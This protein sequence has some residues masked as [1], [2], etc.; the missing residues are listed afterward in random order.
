MSLRRRILLAFIATL[1][2]AAFATSIWIR[3]EARDSYALVIEEMMVD[4]ANLLAIQLE[5]EF[6]QGRPGSLEIARVFETFKKRALNAQILRIKKVDPALDIY[7][8]DS[9]GR[10][11]YSSRD[12]TEIGQDYSQ[13]RDIALTLRGEY[14]ARATRIDQADKLTS[15]YYIGAPIRVGQE[16]VGVV[17][18]IKK[19]SSITAFLDLFLEKMVIGV[20]VVIGLV[21][22]FGS[23]L[24]VWI[25]RP[26]EK[27]R[28]YALE[29]AS[30]NKVPLPNL[31]HRELRDL[32]DAFEQMRISLEGRKTIERFIQ[33]LTHELKSPLAAI[34]GSS[35]LALEPMADA[36]RTRFLNNVLDEAARAELVLEQMMRIAALES[37][38][39][40]TQTKS[41][42]LAQLVGDAETAL[43]GI[44]E[45]SQV[46]F[47]NQWDQQEPNFV[48][49]ADPFLLTQAIRNLLQNAVEFSEAGSE[50]KVSLVRGDTKIR[51]IVEDSGSG[52]P[53]FAKERMFEKFV[54]LERPRTGKKGTGLGLSF[55]REVIHLH[56]G[57]IEVTSP[58]PSGNRGTRIE[59]TL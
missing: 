11:L 30:G 5:T 59:I 47:I 12:A 14:G 56:R 8:T 39:K 45:K 16:I 4:V 2:T 57:T 35:E 34:R 37:Q 54:S 6:A 32:A 33:S 43:L 48:V 58:L 25:T 29:I 51:L 1:F 50:V 26:I 15:V 31:P 36:Q 21:I 53:E 3:N 22:F 23:L 44:A 40:L 20:L 38:T 10:V 24:F 18:A 49:E 41:S 42:N 17:T 13:W 9:T 28:G 27:L 55:V 52:I 19:R 46:R 7:V